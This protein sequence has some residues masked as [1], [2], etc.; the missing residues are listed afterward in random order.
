VDYKELIEDIKDLSK[1]M[2]IVEGVVDVFFDSKGD[3]YHIKDAKN[4]YWVIVGNTPEE[5]IEICLAS[6]FRINDFDFG[7]GGLNGEGEYHFD[8]ILKYDQG[9]DYSRGCWY[10]EY[11]EFHFQQTFLEREREKKLSEL[12]DD[13]FDNLFNI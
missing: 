13:S 12:L 1:T 3:F 5:E 6:T 9:D 4:S 2:T 7:G 11:I 8:A 10:T